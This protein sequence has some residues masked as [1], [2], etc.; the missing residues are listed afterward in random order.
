MRAFGDRSRS[1]D[2]RASLKPRRR[3][4]AELKPAAKVGEKARGHDER[5]RPTEPSRRQSPSPA[6]EP[7]AS[8]PPASDAAADPEEPAASGQR[9]RRRRKRTAEEKEARAQ[10]RRHGRRRRDAGSPAEDEADNETA[11]SGADASLEATEDAADASPEGGRASADPRRQQVG[12]VEES[13]EEKLFA[14]VLEAAGAR[15]RALEPKAASGKVARKRKHPKTEGASEAERRRAESGAEAAEGEAGKADS[16]E[17]AAADEGTEPRGPPEKHRSAKGKAENREKKA[18]KEK[19]H[20]EHHKKKAKGSNQKGEGGKQQ[21]SDAAAARFGALIRDVYRRKNPAKLGDVDELLAK[22]AGAEEELYD[23]ICEKYGEEPKRAGTA[24]P[25][26]AQPPGFGAA[27][28]GF[29]RKASA[30]PPPPA[31]AAVPAP[32]GEAP[33]E[34]GWPFVEEFSMNSEDSDCSSELSMAQARRSAVEPPTA[35]LYDDL[36]PRAR[37]RVAKASTE[38]VATGFGA[39]I[40]GAEAPSPPARPPGAFAAPVELPAFL[41]RW[42][43]T[44]GNEVQVDWAR[45]GSRG[46]QLDVTLSRPRSS[47]E[48]IKLCVKA[49]GSGRFACGHYDLDTQ[50]STLDRI[51]WLDTRNKGKDS[52]W[53]RPGNGHPP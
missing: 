29:A 37:V 41:G 20:K 52:V 10:G 50:N 5:A 45:P 6:A 43:D 9:R 17:A 7:A 34:G 47:R 49:R 26:R 39:G 23:S 27:A 35:S 38:H 44:M 19:K 11:A 25:P 51:I 3:G 40:F 32:N 31:L 2:R 13:A 18:K 21:E 36:V 1:S 15:E 22:Y 28:R 48:P 12:V 8:P 53:E 30:P 24:A 42:R 33:Q 16:S 4:A 46:G 14:A